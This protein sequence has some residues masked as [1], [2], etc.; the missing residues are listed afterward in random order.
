MVK[1]GKLAPISTTDDAEVLLK[2]IP[3]DKVSISMTINST[4]VIL[5]A[6]LIVVAESNI[7]KKLLKGT[8]QIIL[9]EYIARGTYIYPPK[10]SMRLITDIFEYCNKN[11][12]K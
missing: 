9:K 2:N 5:L 12:P 4:A 3:L 6:M 1:L 10:Q 11:V 8:I 7:D